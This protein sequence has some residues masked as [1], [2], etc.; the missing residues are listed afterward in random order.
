MKIRVNNSTATIFFDIL[1]AMA[2]FVFLLSNIMGKGA[3]AEYPLMS[4]QV[5]APTLIYI[6]LGLVLLVVAIILVLIVGV[7]GNK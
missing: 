6:G 3:L 7:F 4:W 5:W 1:F 2:Q